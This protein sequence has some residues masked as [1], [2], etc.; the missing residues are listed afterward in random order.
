MTVDDVLSPFARE[1][2]QIGEPFTDH[3][4]TTPPASRERIGHVRQRVPPPWAGKHNLFIGWLLTYTSGVDMVE[5]Y[6][7]RSACQSGG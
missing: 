2:R 7:S 6:L 4:R 5:K 1:K 3:L